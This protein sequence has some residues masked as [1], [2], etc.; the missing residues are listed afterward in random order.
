MSIDDKGFALALPDK[1]YV[2]R[3]AVW[4][5]PTAA[6]SSTTRTLQANDTFLIRRFRPSLDGTLF[7]LVDF[8]MIPEFAGTVP[9]PRR[10]YRRSSLGMAAVRAG[11]MKGPVGLERLQSDA[12]LALLERALDQNLCSQR[13]VGVVSSGATSRAASFHTRRRLQRRPRQH[14]RPTPTSTTPRT[15]PGGCSSVPSGPRR[16]ATSATSAS[17]CAAQTGNRKGPLPP[18]AAPAADRPRAVPD[19]RPEHVLPVPGTGDRHDRRDDGV[20]ARAGNAHQPSALLLLRPVR[21]ARRVRVAASRAFRRGTPRRS[22]R[23]RRRTRPPATPSV[24]PRTTTAPRPST[25]SI[26]ARTTWARCSSRFGS[27]WLGIDDATFPT[28]ANPVASARDGEGVRGRG[29]LGSAAHFRGS[30]C[31][32]SRPGSRAGRA[33]AATADHAG[34]DGEP[35]DR[36]RAAWARAGELLSSMASATDERKRTWQRRR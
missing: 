8:R 19:R 24:A 28:Y 4:C 27:G 21:P 1:S 16:C 18:S 36:V 11:K 17:G 34:D 9:D 29:E 22:S 35:A 7:S 15:S 12:D 5:R 23:S 13:D 32:T 10:L 33:T 20:D 30:G 25:R 2:L 3:F 6:S 26:P 14:R 31:S